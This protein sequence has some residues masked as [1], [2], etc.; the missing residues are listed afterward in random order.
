MTDNQVS[1]N[2]KLFAAGSSAVTELI[3]GRRYAVDR[4]NQL[5]LRVEPYEILWLSA[6]GKPDNQ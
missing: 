3:G 6:S 2:D 4:D 5:M 1:D